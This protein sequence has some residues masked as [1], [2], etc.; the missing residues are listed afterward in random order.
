M[1]D[2]ADDMHDIGTVPCC[3]AKLFFIGLHILLHIAMWSLPEYLA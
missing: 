2:H 3:G 1:A